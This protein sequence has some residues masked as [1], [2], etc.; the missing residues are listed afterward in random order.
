MIL[1]AD[2]TA[3]SVELF[4]TL[5]WIPFYDEAKINKCILVFKCLSRDCPPYLTDTLKSNRDIHNR[6]S[7]HGSANLVCPRFSR[8][9]EGGQSFAASA[10]HLWNSFRNSLKKYFSVKVFGKNLVNYF[11]LSYTNIEHF[12]I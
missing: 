9:T 6:I 7:R 3:N 8:E 2:T 12:K 1:E 5:D 11:K 4:K 10:S